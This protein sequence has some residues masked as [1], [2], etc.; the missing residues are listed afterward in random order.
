MFE[1]SQA[2][3]FAELAL[4]NIDRPLPHKLDHLLTDDADPHTADHVALHPA[5]F[6]SFDWHSSVH[7]HWLLV[8]VL[9]LHPG[10]SAAPRIVE[11]LSDHLTGDR[12]ARERAY[13]AWPAGATFERPYGWAWLL[14]LR[15]ELER[16]ASVDRR[17]RAW[18]DA[19]DPLAHDLATRLA[20]FAAAAPY[21]IRSGVHSC[22]AFALTLA[23]DHARTCA[24]S[25]HARPSD[26]LTAAA[27]VSSPS[28]WW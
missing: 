9:R 7:M 11:R 13:C 23:L 15:A 5:F 18:A 26:S 6:G 2:A 22:T 1:E 3:A 12:I 25:T 10:L 14:E 20:A 4:G 8:R 17:A 28:T 21:P 16:L 19:V 27:S 24:H